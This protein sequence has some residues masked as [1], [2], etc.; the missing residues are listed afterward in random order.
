MI[1]VWLI[2]VPVVGGGLGWALAHWKPSASRWVSLVALVFELALA[3]LL[4]GASAG[5]LEFIGGGNWLRQLSVDWIPQ[6]GIRFHLGM[7]G[8]SLWMI[9]LSA[10]LGIL[11]I[12]ASWNE[13]QERVGLFHFN[14]MLILTGV[15]G[16]FLA[17]DL[18][19][20][21]FFFELMLIPTYFL[22]AIW[23]DGNRRYAAA[24][25]FLFTQISG[26][27][28]LLALLGLYFIHGQQTGIYSF[29]YADLLKTQLSDSTAWWLML[30]FAAAFLVKLPAVPFHSW[31]PEAYSSA[32]TAGSI[33]LAGLLSK[34]GAYGLIRFVVPF[35]PNAAK[36][37]A[38]P[39]MILAVIG[40]LY[41]G[42]M[43]FA[44]RDFK[45]LI[46]Y[47]SVSHLGF[48]LLAIFAWT[49]LSL[50]GAVMQMICHGI[51]V[52]GLFFLAGA[53]QERLATREM[54][55]MGGFWTPAPKMGGVAMFFALASLGMPGLGNFIGEFLSLIGSFKAN[56]ALT[57]AATAGFIFSVIYSL[58]MIQVIFWGPTVD[59][60]GLTDLRW[61]ELGMAA[62][63]IIC[64]VWLGLY[65]KP[66]FDRVDNA[67]QGI[68]QARTGS[69]ARVDSPVMAIKAAPQ[70]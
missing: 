41:G 33:V 34:T 48:V 65:P 46:A 37:F 29:D 52:A 54:N 61:R 16:V 8:L 17:L 42:M 68:Q 27:F 63:M 26:L 32:P 22:I 39:A 12:L 28:M 21:Y 5:P 58:W 40:I 6:I 18:F 23:G 35:F 69:Q 53:L 13:I 14:L 47:G 66:V 50:Q 51:S 45:R 19:L 60:A 36:D 4:L 59:K 43:A 49:P 3:A 31:L 44:Q 25:F 30:G 7:D 67:V 15:I 2:F 64:L 38:F 24:K 20:F 56:P 62:A 10:F 9:L 55:R 11:S 70:K 1:L 57:A